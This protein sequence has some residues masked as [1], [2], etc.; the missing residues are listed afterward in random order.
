MAQAENAQSGT[1]PPSPRNMLGT[2]RPLYRWLA[3]LAVVVIVLLASLLLWGT[4][5]EFPTT[6]SSSTVQTSGGGTVTLEK[7]IREVT[8]SAIDDGRVGHERGKLAI[9]KPEYGRDLCAGIHRERPEMGALARYR[10]RSGAAFVC[11]GPLAAAGLHLLC[12]ALRRL[13]GPVGKT[14]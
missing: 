13:H 2:A 10:G 1:A 7:T 9:R 5:M 11:S 14:P 6:V 8:G 4:A 12:A 3:G